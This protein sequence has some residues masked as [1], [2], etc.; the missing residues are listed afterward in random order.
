M[1]VIQAIESVAFLRSET[2]IGDRREQ[3]G[4]QRCGH[5]FEELREDE[6]DRVALGK[7]AIASRVRHAFDGALRAAL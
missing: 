6:A 4:G 3:A 7:Q 5:A 2:R 1:R